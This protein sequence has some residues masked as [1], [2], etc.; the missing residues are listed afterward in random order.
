MRTDAR[1]AQC[2]VCA[3]ARYG[4][5]QGAQ[6]CKVHTIARYAHSTFARYAHLQDWYAQLQ[7]AHCCKV[8]TAASILNCKLHCTQM[9]GMQL[10]FKYNTQKTAKNKQILKISFDLKK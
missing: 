10:N 1:N 9:Q 4:K 6:R 8:H 7:G 3:I 5:L 2:K